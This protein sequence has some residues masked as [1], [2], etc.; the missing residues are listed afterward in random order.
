MIYVL[1]FQAFHF[2]VLYMY[3]FMWKNEW[4]NECMSRLIVFCS[5]D[6]GTSTV[7][8]I[9]NSTR[10]KVWKKIISWFSTPAFSSSNQI[11]LKLFAIL[12]WEWKNLKKGKSHFNFP[13]FPLRYLH[14]GIFKKQNHF[15]KFV[16][17]S[18]IKTFYICLS[19]CLP[20]SCLHFLISIQFFLCTF[21]LD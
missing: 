3:I 17:I 6:D 5:T 8:S 16:P 15:R 21:N 20:R 2:K 13:H 10:T 7:N 18:L 9:R 1:C 4:M 14:L 11:Q 12:K 19:E